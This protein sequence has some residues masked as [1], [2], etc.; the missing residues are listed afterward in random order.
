M[1]NQ[2]NPLAIIPY[3]VH[4]G[5]IFFCRVTGMSEKRWFSL[6]HHQTVLKT[7]RADYDTMPSSLTPHSN[8]AKTRI[9][10]TTQHATVAFKPTSTLLYC[11]NCRHWKMRRQKNPYILSPSFL[12]LRPKLQLW[13][14]GC[15][16]ALRMWELLVLHALPVCKQEKGAFFHGVITGQGTQSCNTIWSYEPPKIPHRSA[17]PA[18]VFTGCKVQQWHAELRFRL[19]GS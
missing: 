9:N 17:L 19:R 16:A 14:H 1:Q 13:L 5:V 2:H 7:L 4:V 18:A 8:W 3:Y 15:H 6:H 10:R 12:Y 11:W